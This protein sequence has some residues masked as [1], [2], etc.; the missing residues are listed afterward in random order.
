M[1]IVID[2]YE[3]GPGST[4]VGRVARNIIPAL[5]SLFEEDRFFILTREVALPFSRPNGQQIILPSGKR[6]YF[7]WQN[8]LFWRACLRLEPHLI[9]AFNYTLPLICPWPSLLFVHDISMIVHPEWFPRK[10][11]RWR[12]WLLKRSLRQA[13]EVIVPSGVTEK[14]IISHLKIKRDKIKVVYYGLEDKFQPVPEEDRRSFKQSRGLE[15]RRIVGFLGSIFRRR[16]LPLL[17]EAVASLRVEFPDICLYVVGE[18]KTYPP[19][20]I[21][22]LLNQEWIRWD[23][24]LPEVELPLFYSTCDVFAYLSEYEGFGL[25]PL[26]ALACGSVPIVLN[27]S[28]LGEIM[29]GLAFLVD[30][31]KPGAVGQA[32]K[33]ALVNP[34][35]RQEIRKHF[36]TRRL[37]FSWSRVASIVGEII[38][39]FKKK[40]KIL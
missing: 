37:E 25:P 23:K 33:E 14:E 20:P 40:R 21:S 22:S 7:R 27:R 10:T 6:G 34:K 29:V 13:D 17:V 5:A 36:E 12:G 31:I 11:A 8:G 39:K 24:F 9:I 16:N 30:E 15:N 35:K 28:S 1:R 3:L 18:D 32:I 4:G 38:L 2:G 19:E 26:E